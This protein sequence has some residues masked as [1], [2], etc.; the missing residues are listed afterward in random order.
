M[1]NRRIAL[2]TQYSSLSIQISVCHRKRQAALGL[3]K[4]PQIINST[5]LLSSSLFAA[6]PALCFPTSYMNNISANGSHYSI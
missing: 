1:P 5:M 2:I 6:N 3:G 4:G